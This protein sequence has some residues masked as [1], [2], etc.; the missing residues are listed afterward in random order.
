MAGE[1]SGGEP[2]AATFAH[3]TFFPQLR[4]LAADKARAVVD[5]LDAS[6]ASELRSV[7]LSYLELEG[8]RRGVVSRSASVP[9]LAA[10]AGASPAS[11]AETRQA[12]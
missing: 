6:R 10:A 9:S 7:C 12:R 4:A 2:S 3:R 1:G 8:E 5:S 11:E